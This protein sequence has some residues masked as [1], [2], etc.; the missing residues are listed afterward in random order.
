MANRIYIPTKANQDD[1]L[2][3]LSTLQADVETLKSGLGSSRLATVTVRF[4]WSG[5]SY[6]IPTDYATKVEL[7]N[8]AKIVLRE[9]G[10][11]SPY[12][13]SI[14]SLENF[15]TTFSLFVT[16]GARVSTSS[17]GCVIGKSATAGYA[18]AADEF[19]LGGGQHRT[20]YL[21]LQ[22]V[23]GEVVEMF[24][25]QP[26]VANPSGSSVNRLKAGNSYLGTRITTA[27]G[28]VTHF[29][30]WTSG[31]TTWVDTSL[32]K[33]VLWDCPKDGSTPTERIISTATDTTDWV[34]IEDRLAAIK[35]IKIGT[36]SYTNGTTTVGDNKMVRYDKLYVKTTRETVNMPVE[37]ADGNLVENLVDCVV[38]W[39]CDTKADA[40]YHLHAL[41]EKYARNSDGTYTTTECKHGYIAR[42]PIGNT[43][44]MTID[45]SSK[46]VPQWKSGTGS[47]YVPG[48]RSVTLR[49]ARMLNKCTAT[50]TF[51]GEE[52]ITIPPDETNRT[53]GVAGTAEISFLA[54]LAYLYFGVN[55]QGSL[56]STDPSLNIFPG[57]SNSSASA[58][59]NGNSDHVVAAGK[60]TGATDTRLITNTISFLGVEDALWSSTGWY[61][62]D[63]TLVTRRTITTSDDGGISSNVESTGWLFA[64]DAADVEPGATAISNETTTMESE[65][66]EGQLKAVGYRE[67]SFAGGTSWYRAGLDES[68]VLRDAFLPASVQDQSNINT[69]ACDAY[70]RGSTPSGFG[71]FSSA[72]T[73]SS[74]EYVLNNNKLYRCI[75]KHD[76]GEWDESHFSLVANETVT[77]RSYWLVCLGYYRGYGLSLGCFYVFA[78]FA[79]SDSYGGG[80]RARPLLRIG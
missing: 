41:F 13:R 28:T 47:C 66:Y 26:Y 27:D 69:G 48:S 52:A 62:E 20:I 29:G 11:D 70:W 57:I 31:Q 4:N 33:V 2:A 1:A 75:S 12:E 68:A 6:S 42:Y 30:H 3:K 18:V 44:S 58:T 79:L 19:T 65:S 21:N 10:I 23:T 61:W 71:N 25:A 24:R 49:I 22:K 80:W 43:V 45:G 53:W 63:V 77:R 32:T 5:Q 60:F 56:S 76:A 14:T 74:G 51:D 78:S 55:V 35:N 15:E 9:N 17:V 16:D 7:L 67:A 38:K 8:G 40:D 64:Q 39:Y 73:Y 59:T 36:L 37:D 50:L 34:S 54:N 46:T 72:S